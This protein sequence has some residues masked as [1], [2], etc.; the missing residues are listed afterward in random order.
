MRIAAAV[1]AF[2][3]MMNSVHAREA[4]NET[5]RGFGIRFWKAV[6]HANTRA[7]AA[8]YAPEVTLLAGSEL[9]KKQWGLNP[10]G[11]RGRDVRV[12]RADL[13]SGYET[14][15]EKIG[16]DRWE[17]I[18]TKIGN[19]KVSFVVAQANDQGFKG[20]KKGDVLM[21]VATGPGDD[22]LTFVLSQN[23]NKTW[24][25]RMEATDY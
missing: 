7:M 17:S 23:A 2:G 6:S 20:V 5:H 22:A 13:I 25:V 11:D 1:L 10:D 12:K 24:T 16:K 14:M 18:F 19:D 8:C 3:V 9:L 21:K 4:A 15:I